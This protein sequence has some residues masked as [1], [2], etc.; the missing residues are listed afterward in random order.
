MGRFLMKTNPMGAGLL[1]LYR[2]ITHVLTPLAPLFLKWRQ[3]KGKEEPHRLQERMGIPSRQRPEGSLIWFHGASVGESLSLLPLLQAVKSQG[4]KGLITTTT[5]SA[6]EVLHTR[7]PPGIVHQYI[8]LD[9]PRFV[10]RFLTHW[11]PDLALIAES[12]LWPNLFCQAKKRKI[13]LI[14][15]NAHISS[16]TFNRWRSW[17]RTISTLLHTLDLCLAQTEEDANR[18]LMLGAPRVHIA[19]NLKYDVPAPPVNMKKLGE[20]LADIGSRPTWVAA[21][22]HEGE[23]EIILDVHQRLRSYFPALLT[24]IAP[25]HAERGE[26]I[27]AMAQARNISLSRRSQGDPINASTDVYLVDTFGEMGLFYRLNTA[28]FLGKSLGNRGGHNPIEPAKLGNALLHGPHVVNFEETYHLLD[29]NCG[30]IKVTSEDSLAHALFLLLS[31][32]ALLRKM[33]RSAHEIIETTGGATRIILQALEPY[34][35]HMRLD[36]G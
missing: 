26:S 30:A 5:R 25:R 14:L 18:F 7:L 23:E 17:P 34:F 20:L 31:D 27:A 36:R 1:P 28:V 3:R 29:Q 4:V 15:A 32:G 21:S 24:F 35:L 8:P 9:C 6:S 13:P 12:E 22:T 33:A 19:G 11:K 10:D 16:R 2:G